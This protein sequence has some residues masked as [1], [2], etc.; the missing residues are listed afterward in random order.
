VSITRIPWRSE[1]A[2]GEI[3]LLRM[4][5]NEQMRSTSGRKKPLSAP[6]GER[7]IAV[8]ATFEG[9]GNVCNFGTDVDI[10]LFASGKEGREASVRSCASGNDTCYSFSTAALPSDSIV[11]RPEHPRGWNLI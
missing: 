3:L 11:S 4:L 9:L 5:A 8:A 1:V 7:I 10:H 2:W 6:V